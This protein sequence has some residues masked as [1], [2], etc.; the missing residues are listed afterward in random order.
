MNPKLSSYKDWKDHFYFMEVPDDY[1]L[2]RDF[3]VPRPRMNSM[4]SETWARMRDA[5]TIGYLSMWAWVL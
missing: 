3:S 1:R 5:L 4:I 2:R